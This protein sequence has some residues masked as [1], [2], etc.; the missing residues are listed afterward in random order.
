[1]K[2]LMT[3]FFL[4]MSLLVSINISAAVKIVECEDEAGNRSFQ[5]TCPP[6]STVIEQKRISTG[7]TSEGKKYTSKL[8]LKK[9]ATLYTI[10]ECDTCDEVREFLND[11]EV[12]ITE[13]DVSKDVAAQNEL[14]GIAGELRVPVTII[15][16]K[17]LKGYNRSEFKA[18]IEGKDYEKQE[19]SEPEDE[20]NTDNGA[21]D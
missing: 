3:N 18:A 16:G 17:T 6:G 20:P 8:K 7:G 5:K 10:P 1:M 11:N 19:K 12:E 21:T 14:E 13:K 9:S 4:V 2:Q 15:D